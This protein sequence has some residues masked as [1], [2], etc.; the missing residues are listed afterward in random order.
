M[1]K[2]GQISE[3]HILQTAYSNLVCKVVYIEG[4]KFING[5]EISLVV[6]EI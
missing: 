1:K 3:T 4:I 2:I 5:I 6:I